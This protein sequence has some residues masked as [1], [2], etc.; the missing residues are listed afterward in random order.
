MKLTYR[1]SEYDFVPPPV[2]MVTSSLS[3]TYRGQSYQLT[4]P[5]HIPVPQ[6]SFDLVYRGHA[7]HTTTNGEVTPI[8]PTPSQPKLNPQV[9]KRV[10]TPVHQQ[11]RQKLDAAEQTHRQA[12]MQRLQHRLTVAQAKGDET[13]I[14]QLEEEMRLFA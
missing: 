4:Y 9:A 3:G 12:I 14:H 10:F 1:G 13:L 11:R 2:D 6:P 7:Y 5:R 8:A